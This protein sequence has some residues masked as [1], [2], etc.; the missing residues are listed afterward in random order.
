[1]KYRLLIAAGIV[2]AGLCH[3]SAMA[4]SLLSGNLQP[5]YLKASVGSVKK[6]DTCLSSYNSHSP[7]AS[8]I[9]AS[10][11]PSQSTNSRS[12]THTGQLSEPRNYLEFTPIW[13]YTM[14]GY[15][16]D[17]ETKKKVRISDAS[18][19]GLRVAFGDQE[20]SQFEFYYSH[21]ETKLSDGGPFPQD[22]LFDLDVDYFHIG[23][24]I[25]RDQGKWRPYFTGTL[26]LTRFNPEDSGIDSETRFS[27]GFG[28]GTH[29][30]PT[31]RVGFYLGARALVTFFNSEFEVE[32]SL[33]P[34]T[35]VR[36]KS[37]AIWQF[38]V[39]AGFTLVF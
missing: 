1:M 17:E 14:G 25:F 16:E 22:T 2:F 27:M 33:S 26:G 36:F 9:L 24:S 21:Q 4:E 34:G 35:T 32:S 31:E 12:G 13:A 10:V 38:Q 19:Y 39:F 23:G 30:F 5:S 28:G 3:H 37:D 7:N 18:S 29:Y 11:L 8:L 15:F 6:T 20:F